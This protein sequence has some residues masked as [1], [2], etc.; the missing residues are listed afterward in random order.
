MVWGHPTLVAVCVDATA[1]VLQQM[2]AMP[3]HG[4]CQPDPGQTDALG[5]SRTNW[6]MIMDAAS[7]STT[8]SA[9]ALDRVIQRY[10]PAVFGFIRSSGKSAD[11]ATD[12]TQGFLCDVLLGRNLLQTATPDRGRF[13]SLLLKSVSNYV[14]EQHRHDT[15]KKRAPR[16]ADGKELLSPFSLDEGEGAWSAISRDQDPEAAF[17]AQWAASLV[18]QVLEKVRIDCMKRGQQAY[19]EVF[20][21]RIVRPKLHGEPPESYE[22][23][24]EAWGIKDA[25]QA[26]NMMVTIKRR[27]ARALVNEAELTVTDSMITRTE[28]EDLLQLLVHDP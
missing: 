25:A 14:R 8:V 3:D 13:R 21:R 28:L 15:R 5:Y 22:Q 27:F 10:W 12:L 23:L 17:H 20:A 7:E 4:T 19:W 9:T 11:E 18:R 24:V 6:S 1:E 16:T 2:T 26:A